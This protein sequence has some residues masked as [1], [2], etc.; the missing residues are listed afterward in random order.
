[1]ALLV[2]GITD[3]KH[4]QACNHNAG[5]R[6]DIEAK[7]FHHLSSLLLIS[8]CCHYYSANVDTNSMLIHCTEC[9][10]V[11]FVL[12]FF[13]KYDYYCLFLS[14]MSLT[15]ICYQWK[16]HVVS[17]YTKPHYQPRALS[18]LGTLGSYAIR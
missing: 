16:Y 4:N 7:L 2:K 18:N 6:I 12:F 11:D 9:V 13:M 5:H 1:M 15:F 14:V 8:F 3:R 17:V 10:A